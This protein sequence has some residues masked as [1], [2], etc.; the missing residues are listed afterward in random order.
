MRRSRKWRH[1]VAIK[2]H[3]VQ[4]L[5]GLVLSLLLI[6]GVSSYAL[7]HQDLIYTL[8]LTP[9]SVQGLNGIL[10]MPLVHGS[11]THLLLNT[12]T[13][14][15]FISL[16]LWRGY[17]YF[18]VT[19]LMILTFS[20]VVLWLIGRSGAHIGASVLIFGYLGLLSA[21]GLF[22]R[23]FWPVLCSLLVIG[24][25]GRLLWGIVPIDEG[26]SWEGHICGLLA[27]TACAWLLSSK[28]DGL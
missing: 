9:R 19:T 3:I 11:M 13:L 15:V 18:L 16:V 28:A 17:G 5:P 24:V 22:E 27:G 7:I 1:P 25:Y 2:T 14:A 8:A 23:Q 12:A 10:S 26:V 20:G 21:R 6:W 4:L